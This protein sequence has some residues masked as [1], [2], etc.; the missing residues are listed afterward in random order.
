MKTRFCTLADIFL[1][2]FKTK[3]NKSKTSLI[4]QSPELEEI[5]WQNKR[6]LGY[7]VKKTLPLLTP[8]FPDP[9][10]AVGEKLANTGC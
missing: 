7:K 9:I 8:C 4:Q 3:Q 10:M 1:P 6:I 5:K 2:Q